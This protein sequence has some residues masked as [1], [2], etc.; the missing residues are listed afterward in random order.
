MGS[1]NF[2][3]IENKMNQ[4]GSSWWCTYEMRLI[5]NTVPVK[6]ISLIVYFW[7]D[8]IIHSCFF[9][10]LPHHTNPLY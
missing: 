7:T 3:D 2:Q 9:V 8:S 1:V 5:S 4:S 10:D 6:D